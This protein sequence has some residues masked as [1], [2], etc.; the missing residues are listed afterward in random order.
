MSSILK[1]HNSCNLNY[2]HV[3]NDLHDY[4]LFEKVL[5]DATKP[6]IAKHPERRVVNKPIVQRPVKPDVVVIVE[7]PV[8]KN[9]YDKDYCFFFNQTDSL[10]W[11]LQFIKN[12]ELPETINIVVEKNIKIE[13]I[14]KIR[15]SKSILKPYKLTSLIDA[16]SILLNDKKINIKIF[17]LLCVLENINVMYIY[18][19]TYFE[20]I[21]NND[22]ETHIIML[23]D[24][25]KYGYY[26]CSEENISNFRNVLYKID[27]I[28]KPVKTMTSYKLCELTDI[29]TKL[30]IE[31]TNKDTQK[32]HQKKT[33]YELIVQHF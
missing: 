26:G 15:K 29:C 9:R 7:P 19:K 33:L 22:E 16:E 25:L 8:K 14:E 13:Y 21:V 17:F 30:G 2:N 12:E 27:N 6:M 23:D 20:M 4:M 32:P 28:A 24:K 11:C 1:S 18:K 5:I 3:L 31:T 10:F